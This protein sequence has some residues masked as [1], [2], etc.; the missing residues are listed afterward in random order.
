LIL[1][2]SGRDLPPHKYQTAPSNGEMRYY[3]RTE[4]DSFS[5]LYKP[6]I[7]ILLPSLISKI[8]I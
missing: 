4:P 6:A 8:H 3:A 1:A 2:H 5:L 7:D